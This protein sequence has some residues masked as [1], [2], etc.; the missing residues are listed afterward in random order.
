MNCSKGK[1]WLTIFSV[2]IL[3]PLAIFAQ[4]A[5]DIQYK[6]MQ[7]DSSYSFY[8]TFRIRS[9]PDCL[10]DICFDYRHIRLLAPDAKEVQLINQGVNWNQIRYTY[11]KYIFFE[12]ITVWHRKVN[13]EKQ[14]VDFNLIS[15]KNNLAIMPGLISSSG[16]Y[17]INKQG[18]H[19]FV[20]YYQ[21]CQLTKSSLT[22]SYLSRVQKE[23]IQFIYRFS[24]Y[25]NAI[26]GFSTTND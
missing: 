16:F 12:N 5:N 26:C 20:E 25:A 9:Y 8:S 22:K 18:E 11:Q 4:E 23:A 14:R 3:L 6:F 10:L 15:S 24:E 2:M 13:S 19:V 7:T 21:Q 17:Q 1:I